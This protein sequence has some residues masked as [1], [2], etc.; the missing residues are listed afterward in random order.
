MLAAGCAQPGV[1]QREQPR[2]ESIRAI[3]LAED[4]RS[5]DSTAT[6]PLREGLRSSEPAIQSM[7]VRAIGRLEE[8]A[9]IGEIVPLLRSTVAEVRAEAA[10]ALA[11]MTLNRGRATAAS[12]AASAASVYTALRRAAENE[13]DIRVRMV[14]ARSL[15]RIQ[16]NQLEQIQFAE[17]LTLSLVSASRDSATL[18]SALLSMERLARLQSRL[19]PLSRG[20][21]DTLRGI[22]LR[23]TAPADAR[24]YAYMALSA[25]GQV[26]EELVSL[27]VTDPDEQVRR[28]SVVTAS[29]LRAVEQRDRLLN[30]LLRDSS[31]MVRLE[32]VRG[33][34]RSGAATECAP[35]L[36]AISDLSANVALAAIDALSQAGD[37][38]PSSERG[39]LEGALVLLMRELSDPGARDAVTERLS[40]HRGAH[41]LLSLARLSPSSA[42]N[43]LA[44]VASHSSWIARVYAARSAMALRDTSVLTRLALDA[45][46]NVRAEAVSALVGVAG[47]AAAPIYHAALAH[48]DYNVVR[49]AAAGFRQSPDPARAAQALLAS[50][51]RITREE[52]ETSRDT[53]MALLDRIAELASPSD[54]AAVMQYA[55]DF[56]AAVA[57]R[58]AQLLSRWTGRTIRASPRRLPPVDRPPV[59][60]DIAP[61]TRLR[62][63]M[64]PS[65]G[66]AVF[67]VELYTREAPY[68]AVRLVRLVRAGYYNGL[69]FHRIAPNFVVQGGS[70][71]ASEYV[72]DGPFMRDEISLHSHARGTLGISTRGRDTGDAQIFINTVDNPRLDFDYTVFGRI[73]YGIPVV[74]GMLEGDVIARVEV[75]SPGN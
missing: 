55:N 70:P 28:L 42:A 10:N 18:V 41:A 43:G 21:I 7:A 66:G 35:L 48:P 5:T 65:A 74:D 2:R 73:V 58:A 13:V 45:N 60:V 34:L 47:H 30:L 40:L 20:S 17:S 54:S 68:T 33:W 44:G 59:D 38:C 25:G 29:S 32:V 49:V 69:T 14:L 27:T 8:P 24:R 56:D 31:Q 1:V 16:L 63:V 57:D 75:L 53:R 52:K 23:R 67:E 51:E 19:L 50:L 9:L 71:G 36:L 15:T 72:G 37:R 6:R 11:Q 39:A 12:R 3:Q 61:G 26:D 64:S 62:F 4:S 46:A 22:V